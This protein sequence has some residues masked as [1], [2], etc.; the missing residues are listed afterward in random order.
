MRPQQKSGR[1]RGKSNRNKGVGHSPN[2]VYE[3]AGPEGKVR[4]TPQQIIDKYLGL[5]RDAQ[6]SGDR[7]MS[8]NFHQHA[9]HYSRILIAVQEA[10]GLE[11][12]D[13]NQ[14]GSFDRDDEEDGEE[15]DPRD[16]RAD[17]ERSEQPRF[18]NGNGQQ[19]QQ[20][21]QGR[22]D[23]GRQNDQSRGNDQNRSGDQNRQ[24]DRR[25]D[26][27]QHRA[28][29]PDPRPAPAEVK[30]TPPPVADEQPQTDGLAAIQAA[31]EA[32]GLVVETPEN[33]DKPVVRRPRRPRAK[34]APKPAADAGEPTT[35]AA[36]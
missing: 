16:R 11:R 8:E 14:G 10:A 22:R 12:R 7:V 15:N 36:E 30:Q 17:G 34:P 21:Q 35:K 25:N 4:G 33:R 5:A 28:L 32:S 31:Q 2:R 18:E 6:L 27:Q 20:G 29:D 23:G 9:E 1:S 3:S 26:D 19:G 13:Q 24:T